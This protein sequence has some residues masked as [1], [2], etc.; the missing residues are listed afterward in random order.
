[1]PRKTKPKRKP[2]GRRIREARQSSGVTQV[3]LAA[4]TGI[5]QPRL[6]EIES[7]EEGGLT[8]TTLERIADALGITLA[9]LV[10]D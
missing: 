4:R 5:S 9:E 8:N 3:D 1:M 2:I 7:S 10:G 6:S